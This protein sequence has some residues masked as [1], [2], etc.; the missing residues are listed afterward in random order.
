MTLTLTQVKANLRVRHSEHD[1]LLTDHMARAKATIERYSRTKVPVDE[2]VET[3]TEFGDY[4]QLGWGPVTALTS[5]AYVDTEGDDQ[6][7]TDPYLR[8]G[9]IYAPADGWPSIGDYSVITATYE[10]GHADGTEEQYQIEAAQLLLIEYW[11]NP[12]EKVDLDPVT[13]LPL[14]VVALCEE[15]H[16]PALV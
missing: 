13:K 6:T 11:Y 4:I 8:D 7:V 16:L 12:P 1:T 2:V 9:R 14:A 10:A 5:L 3:F 15:F